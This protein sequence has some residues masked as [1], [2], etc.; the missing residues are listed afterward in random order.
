M[1]LPAMRA[2][3]AAGIPSLRA[4]AEVLGMNPGFLSKCMRGVKSMPA[5]FAAKFQRLTGY[6]EARWSRGGNDWERATDGVA[7]RGRDMNKTTSAALLAGGIRGW[8]PEPQ[9][10]PVVYGATCA[11][12]D[13]FGQ[14]C[15]KLHR[16]E[17]V[18]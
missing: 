18:L 1:E 3:R 12:C 17:V 10:K 14:A 11:I 4:L 6:P 9:A 5:H 7:E 13:A 15:C 8:R 16:G 2:A